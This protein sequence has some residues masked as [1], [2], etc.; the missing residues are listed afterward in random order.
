MWRAGSA[1]RVPEAGRPGALRLGFDL[2]P[3]MRVGLYGGS[4]N[5]PHTGHLHV[6]RTAMIRLGL[7][8]VVWLASPD[9]PATGQVFQAYGNRVEVLAPSAIAADLRTDGR[10]TVEALDRA[11]AGRLPAAPRLADFVE[12][13]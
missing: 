11:L 2:S 13:L 4:F 12:G 6:A 1:S 8:R 10:W 5:P 7:D 9:C 3:G